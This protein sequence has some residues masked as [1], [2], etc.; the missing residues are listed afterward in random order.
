M[1]FRSTELGRKILDRLVGDLKIIS[2]VEK[3]PSLEGRFMTMVFGPDREKLKRLGQQAARQ[4]AQAEKAAKSAASPA[5]AG[6]PSGQSGGATH[7]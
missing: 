5:A 6:A 7:A 3:T 2:K 4:K 1:L